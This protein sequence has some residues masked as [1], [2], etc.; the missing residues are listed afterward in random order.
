MVQQRVV[1][2]VQAYPHL[3]SQSPTLP[4]SLNLSAFRVSERQVKI[5][6][7]WKRDFC[8]GN[9]CN[10]LT[11]GGVHIHVYS[12]IIGVTAG[13]LSAIWVEG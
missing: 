10:G 4:H 13:I 2:T 6:C 11:L 1:A 7:C 9:T 5:V 8:S 12:I 3:D